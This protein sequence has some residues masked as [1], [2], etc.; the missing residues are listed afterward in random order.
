M[1]KQLLQEMEIRKMMKFANIGALSDGFVDRLQETQEINELAEVED[2]EEAAGGMTS[3]D[4]PM[5][6]DPDAA[7]EPDMSLDPDAP[8]E[9]EEEPLDPGPEEPGPEG[10]S[11]VDHVNDLVDSLRA[12]LA[13]SGD[14]G[15]EA[16][17]L[18][19][20]E[21]T[22]EEDAGGMTSPDAPMSVDP[23][24]ED[25]DLEG[26]SMVDDEPADPE[27]EEGMLNEVARRVARRLSRMRRKR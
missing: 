12:A 23:D 27:D 13:A 20:V 18:I 3:P 1:K 15:M 24:A 10:G 9:D 26:M 17:D 22:G 21:K 4:A 19:S 5:S 25:D 6:V 11:V 2:D 8:A 7:E 14:A 16:A